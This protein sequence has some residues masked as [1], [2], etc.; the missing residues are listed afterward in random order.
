[1]TSSTIDYEELRSNLAE[2]FDTPTGQ[3]H[4]EVAGDIPMASPVLLL[5]GPDSSVGIVPSEL[6]LPPTNTYIGVSSEVAP[7][8]DVE[9]VPYEFPENLFPGDPATYIPPQ[10]LHTVPSPPGI[11]VLSFHILS[12][13]TIT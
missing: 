7:V 4:Q 2:T 1:M 6:V 8:L 3:H 12:S 13:T 11:F 9:L 10:K 5:T